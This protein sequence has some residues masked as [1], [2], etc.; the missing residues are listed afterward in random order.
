MAHAIEEVEEL[1]AVADAI[2][3]IETL[4]RLRIGD[5]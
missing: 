3:I 4:L 5:P 1:A 2:Y